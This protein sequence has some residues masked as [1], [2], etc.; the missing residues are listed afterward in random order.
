MF[1]KTQWFLLL[2]LMGFL[3]QCADPFSEF[4]LQL[5]IMLSRI[6]CDMN[7]CVFMYVSCMCQFLALMAQT[8]RA[9]PVC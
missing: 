8:S 4:C 3:L 1:L 5:D 7:L 9:G 2:K 6:K